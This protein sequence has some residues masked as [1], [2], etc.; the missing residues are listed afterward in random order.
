[1]LVHIDGLSGTG[2]TTLAAELALRGY[3][4]IDAD[5]AFAYFAD[6][7]T[8]APTEVETRA[9][10]IWDGQRLREF[11][12]ASQDDLVFLCGGAMNQNEFFDLFTKRFT[13]CI[14]DDTMR[15]RLLTRTSNGYGKDTGELA[16][17]LELNQSTVEYAE[18]LGSIVVDATRPIN[19]VADDIVRMTPEA[20]MAG[21][22]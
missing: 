22:G 4:A 12:H 13:L 17:Q 19:E 1:V 7:V 3:R 10:W 5:A 16:E 9:N 8:G 20:D 18:G 11:A 15:E 14:D 2:K 6:P 21:S